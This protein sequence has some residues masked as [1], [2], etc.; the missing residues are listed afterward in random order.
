LLGV[1]EFMSMSRSSP[2]AMA[3]TLVLRPPTIP[4]RRK[5]LRAGGV[6]RLSSRHPLG[7]VW[8]DRKWGSTLHLRAGDGP[9]L[10]RDAIAAQGADVVPVSG[11][12]SLKEEHHDCF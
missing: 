8:H 2:P 9:A 10:I 5:R 11:G 12:S 6:V 1:G 4:F 3:A 7:A